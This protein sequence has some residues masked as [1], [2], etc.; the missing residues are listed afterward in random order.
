MLQCKK[1]GQEIVPDMLKCN[2]A[3]LE[4]AMCAPIMNILTSLLQNRLIL[5]SAA[6]DTKHQRN[7]SVSV[8]SPSSFE[9]HRISQCH[10]LAC[11]NECI[12]YK[13]TA[14]QL[15]SQLCSRDFQLYNP[16]WHLGYQGWSMNCALQLRDY[17]MVCFFLSSLSQLQKMADPQF[18]LD[19]A[20]RPASRSSGSSAVS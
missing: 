2:A 7:I 3:H 14:F 18:P 16:S 6:V 4:V 8:M 5:S 19:P 15:Q 20:I 13:I 1:N 12:A 11:F 10:S 9:M 17:M